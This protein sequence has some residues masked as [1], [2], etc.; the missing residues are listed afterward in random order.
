MS[1]S[2]LAF[3]QQRRCALLDQTSAALRGQMVALWRFER[4]GRAVPEA[5]SRPEPPQGA[6]EVD[7]IG[8][9]KQ[10]GRSAGPESLWLG[11][12]MNGDR[13]QFASVS[14]DP[15]APPPT[16]IERRSPERLVLELTGRC[17][18]ALEPVWMAADQAT[19]YLCAALEVLENLLTQVRVS[20]GLSIHTRAQLLAGL[21]SVADSIDHAL[22][23]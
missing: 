14:T 11:C 9:L 23:A 2:S 10:W 20:E 6:L 22:S 12:R 17:L 5:V 4:G 8:T 3:V 18:A 7:V 19:V 16:G 1:E 21:A 13:W 15:P